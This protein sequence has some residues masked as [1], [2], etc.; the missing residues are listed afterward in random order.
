M[1]ALCCDVT[2]YLFNVKWCKTSFSIKVVSTS[3]PA[4]YHFRQGCVYVIRTLIYRMFVKY[5]AP[6]QGCVLCTHT[7]KR[8]INVDPWG[9][10]SF[11][12]SPFSYGRRRIKYNCKPVHWKVLHLQAADSNIADKKKKNSSAVF[13]LPHCTLLT[14][15][16]IDACT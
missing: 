6:L 8:V 9:L 15:L 14:S 2:I 13:V 1:P 11:N 4:N 3:I 16:R 12:Y 10:I 5:M 7:H